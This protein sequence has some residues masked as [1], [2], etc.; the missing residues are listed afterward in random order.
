MRLAQKIMSRHHHLT[1]ILIMLSLILHV[2][3]IGRI[4]RE[5]LDVVNMVCIGH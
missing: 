5:Q 2:G 4:N 3:R 1:L